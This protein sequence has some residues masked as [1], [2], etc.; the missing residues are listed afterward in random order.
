M[1]AKMRKAYAVAERL[2]A[3]AVTDWAVESDAVE[4]TEHIGAVYDALGTKQS[5]PSKRLYAGLGDNRVLS[6]TVGELMAQSEDAGFLYGLAVG[7][8]L[9]KGGR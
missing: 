9:G 6:D 1:T 5:D 7:L 3:Q 4:R 2:A 8:A